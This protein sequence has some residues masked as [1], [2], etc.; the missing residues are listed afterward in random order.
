MGAGSS[1]RELTS[2]GLQKRHRPSGWRSET[3]RAWRDCSNLTKDVNAR[4]VHHAH[5]S[6]F[7]YQVET[8]WLPKPRLELVL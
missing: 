1:G 7:A 6:R 5:V 3:Q 8:A 4:L 2:Q